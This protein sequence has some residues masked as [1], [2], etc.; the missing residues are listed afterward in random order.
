VT[1][2][3]DMSRPRLRRLGVGREIIDLIVLVGAIYALVNLSTVRFIVQGPSMEPTFH[4]DQFL[5]VSRANYLLGEPERGDVV[6]F[7]FPGNQEEDYIK[8]LIGLPGDTVEFRAQQVY[9]NGEPLQEPYIKEPCDPENCPDAV[10]TMGADEYFLMGDNRN[11][12]SDSRTFER[13]GRRVNREHIVGE[14]VIRYWPPADWGFVSRIGY[15]D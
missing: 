6:V 11:R 15:P 7:H 14:V 9:V 8:R 5:I 2:T 3:I 10:Y 4:N 12:S 13:S 1:N